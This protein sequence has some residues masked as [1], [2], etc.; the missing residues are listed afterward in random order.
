MNI[1]IKGTEEEN[2]KQLVDSAN[3]L[4]LVALKRLQKSFPPFFF[5]FA[6]PLRG[7][8]VKGLCPCG[9]YDFHTFRLV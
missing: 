5:L 4:S 2:Q 9:V 7:G 3:A 8:R 6:R 1:L